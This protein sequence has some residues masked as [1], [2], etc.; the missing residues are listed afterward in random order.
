MTISR[1]IHRPG[2]AVQVIAD[3]LSFHH[4]SGSEFQSAHN[5]GRGTAHKREDQDW[6]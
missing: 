5:R 6:D 3:A 4:E 1:R 2:S